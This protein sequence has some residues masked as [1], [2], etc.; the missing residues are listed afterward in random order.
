MVIK[1]VDRDRWVTISK[2]AVPF[3]SWS[4]KGS[5]SNGCVL[6]EIFEKGFDKCL[7]VQNYQSVHGQNFSQDDVATLEFGNF[8]FEN[9]M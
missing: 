2:I 5:R 4:G 3:E 6:T 9:D 8:A 1:G 7:C